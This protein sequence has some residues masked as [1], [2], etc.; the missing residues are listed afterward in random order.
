MFIPSNLSF[1]EYRSSNQK[2]CSCHAYGLATFFRNP[3][4]GLDWKVCLVLTRWGKS[5]GT[6]MFV[7]Q[8]SKYIKP[9]CI[10]VLSFFKC[11]HPQFDWL[12]SWPIAL[13]LSASPPFAKR[14]RLVACFASR[15]LSKGLL[16]LVSSSKR[17]KMIL[18]WLSQMLLR[19]PLQLPRHK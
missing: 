5:V 9:L 19:P 6:R 14:D 13:R 3:N 10:P 11:G 1:W 18:M 16:K 17:P 15:L 8:E 12:W 7:C 2:W 4:P